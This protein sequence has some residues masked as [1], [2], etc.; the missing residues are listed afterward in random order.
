VSKDTNK[1]V[2]Q[3][4]TTIER[5]IAASAAMESKGAQHPDDWE[6]IDKEFHNAKMDL[7]VLYMEA[8]KR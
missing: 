2:I 1:A 7:L 5:V 6:E 4:T 3:V 8:L